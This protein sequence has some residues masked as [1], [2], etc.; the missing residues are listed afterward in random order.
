MTNKKIAF[1]ADSGASVPIEFLDELENAGIIYEP[2][3]FRIF[4]GEEE[5]MD[6]LDIRPEEF[7]PEQAKHLAK[8]GKLTTTSQPPL[9]EYVQAYKNAAEKGA[10][11]IFVFPITS[12]LS[13]SYETAILA[14]NEFDP[15]FDI[16]IIDTLSGAPGQF[17]QMEAAYD[18]Y[19][20]GASIEGIVSEI[21][22][23]RKEILLMLFVDDPKYLAQRAGGLKGMALSKLNIKPVLELVEG[24]LESRIKFRTIRQS[25]NNMFTLLEQ[26]L[27]EK[28]INPKTATPKAYAIYTDDKKIGE[29]LA[30]RIEELYGISSDCDIPVTI[31]TVCPAIGNYLGPGAGGIVIRHV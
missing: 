23:A 16:R 14:K 26:R 6:V 4:F 19:L 11:T 8:T 17:L 30:K 31:D 18:A 1:V 24:D 2:T 29:E 9:I 12:K 15:S 20:G 13:G 7:Y 25:M 22:R 27:K 10:E 28:G 5:I 3:Y 21:E